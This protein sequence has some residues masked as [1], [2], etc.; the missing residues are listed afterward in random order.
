M[1]EKLAGMRCAVFASGEESDLE[2]CRREAAGCHLVICADGGY[3]LACAAGV[4]ADL[5]VGDMDSLGSQPVDVE[6]ERHPCEKDESD[7]ELA[8]AAAA[9]RGAREVVLLG[10]LGGRLDHTF[11][12]L[13]AGLSYA[14]ELGLQARVAGSAAEVCLVVGEHI[15]VGAVGRTCSLLALSEE[16]LDVSLEGFRY[17][18]QGGTLRR[19][20]SRG[21]SNVVAA[22]VARIRAGQ[23]LLLLVLPGGLAP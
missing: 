21:L 13:V 10:A 23:G 14:Q 1:V 3:H 15:L 6:L 22:E 8:L 18:L 4:R 5:V 2:L 7:L 17:P 20:R 19:A 11:F 16:V 9:R 12:N